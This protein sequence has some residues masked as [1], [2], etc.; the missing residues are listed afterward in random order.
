MERNNTQK[1]NKRPTAAA[2]ER[3]KYSP[4]LKIV[5]SVSFK[6]KFQQK[7]GK[8]SAKIYVFRTP[9]E[10]CPIFNAN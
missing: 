3:E 6:Y 2:E 9:L 7:K 4:E 10:I 8:I 1:T 5:D